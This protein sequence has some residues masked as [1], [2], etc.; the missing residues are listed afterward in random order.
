[1]VTAL[2]LI[3]ALLGYACARLLYL[4]DKS[5]ALAGALMVLGCLVVLDRRRRARTR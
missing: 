1:M 4:R 3:G 2:C 5:V